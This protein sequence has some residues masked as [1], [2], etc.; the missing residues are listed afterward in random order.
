[1]VQKIGKVLSMSLLIGFAFVMGGLTWWFV[2]QPS[3]EEAILLMLNNE[4]FTAVQITNLDTPN[5]AFHAVVKGEPWCHVSGIKSASGGEWMLSG[6]RGKQPFD[7][8]PPDDTDLV[9]LIQDQ[10]A[11][12]Q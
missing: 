2:T 11:I 12:C 5:P 4:G 9:T 7:D 10:P 1:M 3:E 8:W 6:Y